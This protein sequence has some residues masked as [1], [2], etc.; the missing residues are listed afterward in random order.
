M[1]RRDDVAHLTYRE[2]V[3]MLVTCDLMCFSAG[4]GHPAAEGSTLGFYCS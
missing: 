3:S 2:C 4:K 1:A